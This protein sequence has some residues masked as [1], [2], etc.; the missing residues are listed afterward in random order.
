MKGLAL[1]LVIGSIFLACSTAAPSAPSDFILAYTDFTGAENAIP[2]PEN[3]CINFD[4]PLKDATY[5]AR[6]S[7]PTNLYPAHG[8]NGA[9][10]ALAP[11]ND[12]DGSAPIF[13]VKR[14]STP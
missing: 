7:T 3:E 14:P 1:T 12:Y 6:G 13:S 10:I 11:R 4:S 8:C 2:L 9:A 5:I